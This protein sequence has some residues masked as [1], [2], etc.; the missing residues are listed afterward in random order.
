MERI[1]KQPGQTMQMAVRQIIAAHTKS[2][3]IEGRAR[4]N[5][6]LGSARCT[7]WEPRVKH[8]CLA[9]DCV[10]VAEPPAAAARI[11]T[12]QKVSAGR[13]SS[14]RDVHAW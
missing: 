7:H 6:S 4:V 14:G 1:P 12:Q 13:Y 8:L 3:L 5:V 10:K 9:V 2:L 11:I